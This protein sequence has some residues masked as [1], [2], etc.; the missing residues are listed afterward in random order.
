MQMKRI[1]VISSDPRLERAVVAAIESSAALLAR[2]GGRT[3]VVEVVRLTAA[4]WLS[5]QQQPSAGCDKVV[6]LGAAGFASGRLSA[7]ALKA[8]AAGNAGR[9][10]EIVVISWQHD[11][12]TVMGLIEGGIDQYMTF[13][14]SLR[15]LCIKLLN[16]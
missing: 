6:V 8:A 4:E 7:A 12:Q 2:A 10:P 16:R 1:A 5:A 9:R 13:P 3:G 15:R 11:E 14:L